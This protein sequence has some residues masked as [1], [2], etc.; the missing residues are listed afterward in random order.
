MPDMTP[1]SA[2]DDWPVWLAHS[3]VPT[4]D[5]VARL[6]EYVTS[7]G[8]LPK[9]CDFL[10]AEPS[11]V[12]ASGQSGAA[13]L[14]QLIARL[15]PQQLN[16]VLRAAPGTNTRTLFAGL[17]AG[18]VRDAS[19][20]PV[21]SAFV[22]V[23]D[24]E[25]LGSL[26]GSLGQLVGVYPADEPMMGQ[27]L[28]AMLWKLPQEPARFSQRLAALRVGARWLAQ[29]DDRVRAWRQ[30][31]ETFERFVTACQQKP[32]L[33]SG[34]GPKSEREDAAQQVVADLAEAMAAEWYPD[35]KSATAK[36]RLLSGL[37]AGARLPA[38]SLPKDFDKKVASYFQTGKWAVP[39]PPAKPQ[40]QPAKPQ[41]QPAPVKP[42]VPSGRATQRPLQPSQVPLQPQFRCP[43]C[44][45]T[46]PPWLRTKVSTAGW[47][48]FILLLCF[49]FPLCCLGLLIRTEYTV[50][51]SCGMKLS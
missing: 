37:I 24:E 5:K 36:R 19:L 12:L 48:L 31:H 21:L 39:A 11:K 42:Q 6:A 45:S 51:Q 35:D 44:Q 40:P 46:L 49:C 7:N 23:V 18:S 50:C 33:L 30:F 15:S 25:C 29:G 14:P 27:R 43:F 2:P 41:P 3:D 13:V 32:S 34:S 17:V 47:V 38:N 4:E 16:S 28:L 1:P 20:K 26:L 10:W 22:R 8:A 9:G